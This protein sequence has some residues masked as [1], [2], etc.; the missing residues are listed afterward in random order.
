MDKKVITELLEQKHQDLFNWL[1]N[2]P[3]EKWMNAPEGKWTVGQH[4]KH[5]LNSIQLLNHAM[6][7]PAFVLKYKYGSANREL[8]P[9]DAVAKRYQEKLA[10]NLERAKQFNSNLKIPPI[11]KKE[12]IL[13]SLKIQ[14]KK[15]QHK[16][17][18]WKDKNLDMLILPHP[19]MGKMPVRELIMWTAHHT[20]HHLNSLK[21]NY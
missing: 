17:M 7:F 16:T 4:A 1:E 13:T 12:E 9:Y 3:E 6:S 19:L 10:A 18:K 15:L 2:E 14:N 21:N 8:R 11:V 20:E 5:L